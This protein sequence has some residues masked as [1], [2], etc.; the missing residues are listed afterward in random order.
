MSFRRVEAEPL[1]N[2]AWRS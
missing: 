2:R 1:V